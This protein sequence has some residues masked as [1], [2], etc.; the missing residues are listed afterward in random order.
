MAKSPDTALPFL[1]KLAKRL[2]PLALRDL[3]DLQAL[4][5]EEE[6]SRDMKHWDTM[7]YMRKHLEQVRSAGV[8]RGGV[9]GVCGVACG[10]ARGGGAAAPRWRC[11]TRRRA[12]ERV[13][14][15]YERVTRPPPRT[16]ST[17][18]TPTPRLPVHR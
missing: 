11:W 14:L 8:R 4:K 1:T 3:G 17:T 9:C 16:P 6:G 5:E 7:Y 10:W 2:R 15:L 18:P 12:G 13:T